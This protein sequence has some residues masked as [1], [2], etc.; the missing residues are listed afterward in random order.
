MACSRRR[1]S[2]S[3]LFFVLAC[4]GDGGSHGDGTTGDTT[5]TESGST[6]A[7]DTTVSPTT[8]SATTTTSSMTT[9]SA[10]T[11]TEAD[12]TMGPV[13]TGESTGEPFDP[14]ALDDAFDDPSL[15]GWS[16]FRADAA[17]VTVEGGQLHMD[18]GL[19]TVWLHSETSI[20]LWKEVQGDFMATA[21]VRA[22]V[23][24]DENTPPPAGYRFGGLMAR[25]GGGGA[26]NY[27]FIVLGT[28]ED[29]SVETKTTVNSSS[30]WQGPSWP[31]AA[32]DVRLCRVG[33]TF[34]LWVRNTGG[35]WQ[36]SNQFERD[37]LP[38]TLQVGPIAYNNAPDPQLRVSFDF[39]DFEPVGSLND[40]SL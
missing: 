5:G 34:Q 11:T 4:G 13:D 36:L 16:T 17:A 22:H 1:L 25:D 9:T 26:E 37:D 29:P 12:T 19:D 28:D 10:T 2:G 24:Q 3:A 27:V 14:N 18:P 8:T 39:V 15:P 30:T 21:A 40:C 35:A 33:A 23:P 38:D 6:G 31:G 32:G 20:L 7:M